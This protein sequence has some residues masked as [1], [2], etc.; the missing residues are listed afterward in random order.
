MKKCIYFIIFA[1]MAISAQGQQTQPAVNEGMEFTILSPE[2]SEFHHIHFPRKNF[3]I[4]RGAIPNMKALYGTRVVV[5]AIDYVNGMPQATLKRK[6][7][8]KFFR[9]FATVKADISQALDAGELSRT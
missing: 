3:I 2:S 1:F 7:G 5:T 6:D 8:R 9:H 4:K